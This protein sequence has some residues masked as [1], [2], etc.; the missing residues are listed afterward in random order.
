MLS[1]VL[2]WLMLLTPRPLVK[3]RPWMP[4]TR[5]SQWKAWR[6]FSL[7][8][9]I[10]RSLEGARRLFCRG[11]SGGTPSLG[12]ALTACFLLLYMVTV[13]LLYVTVVTM[14]VVWTQCPRHVAARRVLQT[15]LC[16]LSRVIQQ[17]MHL[18][19]QE[20][21]WWQLVQAQGNK[22]HSAGMA[23]RL[24][25][26]S[27]GEYVDAREGSGSSSRVTEERVT[28]DRL[29]QRVHEPSTPPPG[30]RLC[31][32]PPQ[33]LSAVREVS[34]A[35]AIAVGRALGMEGR[36]DPG[37]VVAHVP[38]FWESMN[39][40]AI[41]LTT[42]SPTD[43][44]HPHMLEIGDDPSPT[45]ALDTTGS[46]TPPDPD[47][48]PATAASSLPTA[49]TTTS[50]AAGGLD[51]EG[52]PPPMEA[53]ADE[54]LDMELGALVSSLEEP[55]D[56]AT[57]NE[58]AADMLLNP[59]PDPAMAPTDSTASSSTAA[60]SADSA[61]GSGTPSRV[62]RKCVLLLLVPAY[63]VIPGAKSVDQ[64]F[65]N[66]PSHEEYV[67]LH[68]TRLRSL[69]LNVG[70]LDTTTYDTFMQWLPNAPYDVVCLQEI[71]HGL[72]KESTQ[73]VAAG[74]RFITTVDPKTRFQ[75]VAVLIRDSLCDNGE[76]HFQETVTGR[77]LHVRLQKEHLS[78][79]IVGVYQ[80]A[81]HLEARKQNL[82]QRHQLWDQ[83][84]SVGTEYATAVRHQH[85]FVG[86]KHQSTIDFTITRRHHADGL[87]RQVRDPSPE[88][89]NKFLLHKVI[90]L[91]PKQPTPRE[92]RAWQTPEVRGA[93][94]TMWQARRELRQIR[95]VHCAA[96]RACMEAFKKYTV[97]IKAYKL[98]KQQGKTA[99]K[100]LL[101]NEL[102]L[103]AEA[104]QRRDV[105]QLHRIV[106]RLAP[107]S[108]HTAVRIH[109]PQ[110]EILRDAEE[111]HTIVRH[112]EQLF[113]SLQAP[114]PN[115]VVPNTTLQVT[116]KDLYE[117]LQH[118]KYG[119]AVPRSSAPSSA[120]KCCADLLAQALV[121]SVNASLNGQTTPELWWALL[122][123]FLSSVL[124][125]AWWWNG[126]VLVSALPHV[127]GHT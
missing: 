10:G 27:S 22:W 81:L 127:A 79:D 62:N 107:K 21:L 75:G 65:G 55:M 38:P 43:W 83:L 48:A 101:N 57:L 52:D 24:E 80:H 17:C 40:V 104:A 96:L 19:L 98:L 50:V 1:S 95:Q 23:E 122:F 103:A 84:G 68:R 118:T 106:R 51:E 32:P 49:T 30:S 8:L 9:F 121:G 112:F 46:P 88:L 11:P 126:R 92:P 113:Q 33:P 105:G 4:W 15:A 66:G 20:F 94:S 78:I 74:W 102:A 99:R 56:E 13:G 16:I 89:V 67:E 93:V 110:G 18:I 123:G 26:D 29:G 114:E 64:P 14:T 90:S 91:F 120:V 3:P 71:H 12:H 70:G 59:V 72:G 86:A 117:A 37:L 115:N 119:K 60:P 125:P 45:M 85:T 73:W 77:I 124:P 61:R 44:S 39:R 76:L 5:K 6:R 36:A 63:Q 54:M 25:G 31:P 69:T 7:V 41:H 111:H 35:V 28:F 58:V 109:G 82:H 100:A 87:A 47:A 42:F 116:E 34:H 97:F 108:K 53:V 2:A